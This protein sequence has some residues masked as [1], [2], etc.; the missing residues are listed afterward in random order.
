M[1]VGCLVRAA[2]HQGARR[3]DSGR[4]HP[5]RVADPARHARACSSAWSWPVSRRSLFG[6]VP[7]LPVGQAGSHEPAA[8]R[9]EGHRRRLSRRTVEQRPRRRRDRAL[10]R[11]PDV[12]RRADAQRHQAADDGA[13]LRAREHAAGRRSRSGAAITRPPPTR[14]DSSPR[15]WIGFARRPGSSTRRPRTAFRHSVARRR[16]STS[17]AS[18]TRIAGAA[19]SSRSTTGTSGRCGSRSC[20]DVTSPS[21]T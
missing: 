16:T 2:R 3:R 8:R 13:R 7:A 11:A 6:L 21:T 4:P 19:G 10:A 1:A 18:G 17:P 5:A 12:G 14:R 20:R 9:G 15:R